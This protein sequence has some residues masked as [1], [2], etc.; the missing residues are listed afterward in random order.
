MN[1]RAKP[2]CTHILSSFLCCVLTIRRSG[3]AD[4]SLNRVLIHD[5]LKIRLHCIQ[6]PGSGSPPGTEQVGLRQSGLEQGTPYVHEVLSD[7]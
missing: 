6:R 4:F 2:L 5:S 3:G 7:E 1:G